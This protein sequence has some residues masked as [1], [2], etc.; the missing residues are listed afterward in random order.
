[1]LTGCERRLDF[2]KIEKSNG[3]SAEEAGAAKYKCLTV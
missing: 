2:L 1:M 3:S